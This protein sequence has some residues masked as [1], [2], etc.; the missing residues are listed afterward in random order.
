MVDTPR[1]LSGERV[2]RVLKQVGYKVAVSGAD[3]CCTHFG[4]ATARSRKIYLAFP[5]QEMPDEKIL[6][7]DRPDI[8]PRGVAGV[9]ANVGA[10]ARKEACLKAEDGQLKEIPN[11]STSGEK[12]LPWPRGQWVLTG[13]G[14]KKDNRRGS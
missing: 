10:A 13:T 8:L 7:I 4:D 9:V 14:S 3:V 6:D 5:E 12:W 1:G 2:T 11:M